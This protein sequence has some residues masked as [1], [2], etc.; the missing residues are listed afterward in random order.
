MI[1]AHGNMVG[2]KVGASIGTDAIVSNGATGGSVQVSHVSQEGLPHRRRILE[3]QPL[4]HAGPM[5]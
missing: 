2:P 3:R 1:G 5:P 4:V